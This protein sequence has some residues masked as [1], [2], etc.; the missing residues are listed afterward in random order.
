MPGCGYA[1]LIY[2]AMNCYVKLC[3]VMCILIAIFLVDRVYEVAAEVKEENIIVIT[4]IENVSI[5]G[6]IGRSRSGASP[7]AKWI[8]WWLSAQQLD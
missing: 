2:A 3:E 5:P 4:G 8:G 6:A 1:M 7:H